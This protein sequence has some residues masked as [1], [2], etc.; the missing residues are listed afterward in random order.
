MTN[1]YVG[2]VWKATP[3]FQAV[4]AVG[5]E[6]PLQGN[7]QPH[8]SCL[9]W[10]K[11]AIN[12]VNGKKPARAGKGSKTLLFPEDC[13]SKTSVQQ[14]WRRKSGWRE[15]TR[16]KM[17]DQDKDKTPAFNSGANGVWSQ[18]DPPPRLNCFSARKQRISATLASEPSTFH[19]LWD[20]KK[21]PPNAR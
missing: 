14:N 11:I 2:G 3:H 5:S 6:L 1:R 7:A 15:T 13:T 18:A 9:S 10:W 19:N 21:L 12:I 17:D 4:S 20:A 8:A 16:A